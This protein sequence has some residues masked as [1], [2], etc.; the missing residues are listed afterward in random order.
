MTSDERLQSAWKQLELV[1]AFFPRV[2]TKFSI[3]FGINSAGLAVLFAQI[4]KAGR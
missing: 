4:L 1:L 3:A 2:D